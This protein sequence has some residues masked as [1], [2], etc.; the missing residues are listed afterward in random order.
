MALIAFYIVDHP[1][2]GSVYKGVEHYCSLKHSTVTALHSIISTT[3]ERVRD[4]NGFS[5]HLLRQMKTTE[6]ISSTQR[7]VNGEMK[8]MVLQQK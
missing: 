5:P 7:E 2:E 8:H 1:T 4:Y 3:D 6:E